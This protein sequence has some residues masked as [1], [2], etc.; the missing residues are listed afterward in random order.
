MTARRRRSRIWRAIGSMV[1]GS[2]LT[3][4]GDVP[5][6]AL[7]FRTNRPFR[8]FVQWFRAP[9]GSVHKIEMLG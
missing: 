2:I 8:K 4:F 7:L 5:K 9:D 1:A 3:R 6:R